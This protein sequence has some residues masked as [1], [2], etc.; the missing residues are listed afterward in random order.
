MFMVWDWARSALTRCTVAKGREDSQE[1]QECVSAPL[2]PLN[3]AGPTGAAGVWDAT[4]RE[5]GGGAAPGA[6][7]TGPLHM[8]RE[9]AVDSAGPGGGGGLAALVHPCVSVHA[10]G[11]SS[12]KIP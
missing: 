8:Y 5:K 12:R 2:Q 10:G 6:P 7:M 4:P 3:C 1:M 11:L 9:R